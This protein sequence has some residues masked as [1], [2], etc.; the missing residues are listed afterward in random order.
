LLTTCQNSSTIDAETSVQAS[1]LLMKIRNQEFVFLSLAIKQIL[2]ILQPA[3]L[4]LQSTDRDLLSACDIISSVE[5]SLRALRTESHVKSLWEHVSS[6]D[7]SEERETPS[8]KRICSR[9]VSIILLFIQLF[10]FL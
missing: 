3:N 10:Q 1:G 2:E 4:C 7:V 8:R 5:N 6:F 9:Y